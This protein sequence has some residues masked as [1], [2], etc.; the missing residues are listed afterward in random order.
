MKKPSIFIFTVLAAAFILNCVAEA[1]PPDVF[2][3]RDYGAAG[4]GNKLDSQAINSAVKACNKA[5]G[6]TV[7]FSPG[8]YLSGS[9][10][11]KSN[12]ELHLSKGAV[13]KAAPNDINAYDEP[14]PNP[15]YRPEPNEYVDFG[16]CFWE[17][18]LIWA[19]EEKNIA[20]TGL[21]TIDG[22]NLSCGITEKGQGNKTF[23]LKLCRNILLKDITII[24]GGWFCVLPTGCENMVIQGLK[25]DTNRD[26]INLDCCR[27]VRVSDCTI[28]SPGDDSLVFKSSIALGYR[29]P[30]E[31]VTVTN[32]MVS[33][34]QKKNSPG[35]PAMLNGIY[36]GQG[37]G[38]IKFGTE[39]NGGFK[40]IVISNCILR[41]CSGITIQSNDGAIVE[42]ITISNIVMKDVVGGP[43][44]LEITNRLRGPDDP[45]T[46]TMRNINI[47]NIIADGSFFGSSISGTT[48]HMIENVSISNV[49]AMSH[50]TGS[51]GDALKEPEDDITEPWQGNQWHLPSYGFFCR[52][53]KG[54]SF[55]DIR[56]STENAD[57]RPAFVFDDVQQ[58]ELTGIKAQRW[59][60]NDAPVVF[61]NSVKDM[62]VYNCPD[63]P[64][65]KAIYDNVKVSRNKVRAGQDFEAACRVSSKQEGLC[66]AELYM[67]DKLLATKYLW[68]N[69][70]K[71]VDIGFSGLKINTAGK[72]KIQFGDSTQ[73]VCLEV[74]PAGAK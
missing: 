45:V 23:G 11:L 27:N 25:I 35:F 68:L 55:R 39:S 47:S 50:G 4:D 36:E 15:W 24:N 40:N 49:Q 54:L 73:P 74:S 59:E 33:A 72:Y 42:N 2:N 44:N 7:Y 6:G 46:G 70:N 63:L 16:H 22:T 48:G 20:V 32:C 41:N 65:V 51:R 21:G 9:I 3:V 37:I 26:G 19:I 10:R 13:L 56:L 29:K 62:F 17:N 61:R 43:I 53:V 14:S 57:M 34:F 64:V 52:H 31:E 1:N 71:P 67:D 30:T 8:I 38:R 60:G 28:N 69:A 12:V 58:L 66:V 5:G 18:S